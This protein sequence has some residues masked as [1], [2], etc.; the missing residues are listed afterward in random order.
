MDGGVRGET[1]KLTFKARPGSVTM[2]VPAGDE[3]GLFPQ[4]AQGDSPVA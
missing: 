1:D 4:A 3:S 2:C